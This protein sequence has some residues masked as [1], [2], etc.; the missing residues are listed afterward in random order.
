MILSEG[1]SCVRSRTESTIGWSTHGHIAD[2]LMPANAQMHMD[3]T[4]GSV[5]CP[6]ESDAQVMWSAIGGIDCTPADFSLKLPGRSHLL[7]QSHQNSIAKQV[8][9]CSMFGQLFFFCV[10]HWI[11]VSRGAMN[12]AW[13]LGQSYL[14]RG[15]FALVAC[16]RKCTEVWL[17]SHAVLAS[18]KVSVNRR[19]SD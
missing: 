1:S 12:S 19:D 11:L 10:L 9:C 7:C 13:H 4:C 6:A 14:R 17:A 15:T 18:K 5:C 16:R 3:V 2:V 8:S